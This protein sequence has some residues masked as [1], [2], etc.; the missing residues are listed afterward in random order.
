[1]ETQIGIF[2]AGFMVGI[3]FTGILFNLFKNKEKNE[4][5]NRK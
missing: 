2:I 3:C 1:M 5:R 4:S